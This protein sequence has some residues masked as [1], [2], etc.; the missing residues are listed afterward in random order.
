MGDKQLVRPKEE[1]RHVRFGNPRWRSA[2]MQTGQVVGLF[3]DV[4]AFGLVVS[5]LLLLSTPA[6][7]A[8]GLRG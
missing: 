7:V 2:E 3:S 5:G 4:T 1:L 6:A 8:E